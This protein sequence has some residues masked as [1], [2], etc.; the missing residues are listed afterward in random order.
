MTQGSRGHAQLWC[1]SRSSAHFWS[2]SE[3][4][5]LPSNPW[6][7][8]LFYEP[9]LVSEVQDIWANMATSIILGPLVTPSKL[10]PGG[11]QLPPRTADHR[12]QGMGCKN[13]KWP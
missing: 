4:V 9:V 5:D 1:S 6:K 11:L 12:A 8:P 13:H 10:D 2:Q 3:R 7:A